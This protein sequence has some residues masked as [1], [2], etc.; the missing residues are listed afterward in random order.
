[1]PTVLQIG[2]NDLIGNKFNG[3]NLHLYLQKLGWNAYH[4]VKNKESDDDTTFI[5]NE[6]N[7][8]KYT[9]GLITHP[10]FLKSDIIHLHLIHNTPFDINYLP[11]MSSLK[12]V[13]WTLHDAWALG[14]HCIHHYDCLKWQTHCHN[15]EYPNIHFAIERDFTALTFELKKRAVQ[16]ADIQCIVASSW[17]ENKVRNSPIFRGKKI[18]RVPFGVDQRIFTPSPAE[19]A[20]TR[21]GIPQD[22]LVL[23]FRVDRGFKGLEI[24]EQALRSLQLRKATTLITVGLPAGSLENFGDKYTVHEYGWIKDDLLLATLYQ[25]CDLFLMPSEQEAFGMMA[26]EAMSCGKTVLTIN[27][28][29]LQGIVNAPHCGV[30]VEKEKFSTELQKLIDNPN[31][32][33]KRGFLS[34]KFA[35][36]F[37]SHKTYVKSIS[38]I[39]ERFLSTFKNT[40]TSRMILE[41]LYHS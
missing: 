23:F 20:R 39:Y 21:L 17:M 11:I 40:K 12:P 29:A 25:A 14:A 4:L 33:I 5:Y 24:L 41:N 8:K 19:S 27:G 26:I 31:E 22:D 30:S 37:Y 18:Y 10:L 7:S 34:L 1:M 38:N 15:C 9:E 36:E 32:I 2:D 3:H 28:T 16:Q 6:S 13:V 35:L